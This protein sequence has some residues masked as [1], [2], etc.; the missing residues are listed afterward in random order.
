MNIIN[1]I[2]TQSQVIDVIYMYK[3]FLFPDISYINHHS[4][5]QEQYVDLLLLCND[6]QDIKVITSREAQITSTKYITIKKTQ[7]INFQIFTWKVEVSE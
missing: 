3:M 5:K 1:D 4:I 7:N 2:N 6:H